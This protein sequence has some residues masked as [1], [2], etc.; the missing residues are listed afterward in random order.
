MTTP[1]PSRLRASALT[2]R[3]LD[4]VSLRPSSLALID[5]ERAILRFCDANGIERPAGVATDGGGGV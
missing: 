5:R 3:T 4:A 1:L 2:M